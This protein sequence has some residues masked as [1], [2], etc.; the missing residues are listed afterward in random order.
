[1]MHCLL[2]ADDLTGACDAAVPFAMRGYRTVV[3]LCAGQDSVEADVLAVSTESRDM[4]PGEFRRT[5]PR[6]QAA[7]L[8]KKIDSMLR[9][10]PAAEIRTVADL[11][12][13]DIAV[14]T[15]AFPAMGRV[16]RGGVLHIPGL[17]PIALADRFQSLR[18]AGPGFVTVDAACDPDLDAIVAEFGKPG[19]RIVWAGS[20][21]LAAALARS[22]RN[23]TIRP[24]PP[25]RPC[26][27]LFCIGSDHP[28]TLEQLRRL[29]AGRQANVLPIPQGCATAARIR[30]LNPGALVLSGGSTAS[31]V[32]QALAVTHIELQNEI[33]PGIPLGI[34][35]GG[36]FDGFPVVTKSG[37][38]GDPGALIRIH[39]FFTCPKT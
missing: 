2:I 36:V 25:Q 1:M 6:L 21:G 23:G 5:P 37:A 18:D 11:F 10:N 17:D 32:C 19:R 24:S 16:V 14:I 28:V 39:D 27:P 34:L 13:C 26:T 20:A 3:S 31:L 33:A 8:F 38:F 12:A 4:A 7:I 35:R 22:T 15:P 29:R 30:Q 9:G